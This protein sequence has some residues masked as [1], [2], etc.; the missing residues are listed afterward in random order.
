MI[1]IL[2]NGSEQQITIDT[3]LLDF[4]LAQY[5][6]DLKGIAVA[7]NGSLARRSSWAE[8]TLQADDALEVLHAVAGG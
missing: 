7:L 3:L 2:L 8:T 1:S 5:G 6:P 4:L